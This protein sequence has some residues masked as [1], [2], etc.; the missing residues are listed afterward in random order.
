M[1]KKL[2]KSNRKAAYLFAVN[3]FLLLPMFVYGGQN[4]S[5]DSYG[6][7][8]DQNI[9]IEAFI[10]SYRWFGALIYKIYFCLTG[11][12]PISNSTVDIIVFIGMVSSMITVLSFCIVKNIKRDD[13]LTYFTVNLGVL[14]SVTNVWFCDILSFPECIFITTVGVCLCFGAII[15]Y[16]EAEGI[17]GYVVSGLMLI[18]ATGVYQQFISV[19]AIY[20]IAIY[21]IRIISQNKITFKQIFL[22]YLKPAC[23]IVFSGIVYLGVGKLVQNICN[24][25]PNSRVALSVL[26]IKENI[27]YFAR[28][29]HSYLK[30]RGYFS[31]EILTFCFL[32]IGVIWLVFL[33]KEWLKNKETFK[34]VFVVISYVAAYAAAFLPGILSTSHAARA[35]FALFAVFSLFLVGILFL[36]ESRYIK[37]F[38]C[39][40][41]VVVFVM[42]TVVN[43]RCEL[44]LKEQNEVDR[45]WCQ[46]VLSEI[47]KYEKEKDKDVKKIYYCYDEETDLDLDKSESAVSHKYSLKALIGYYSGRYFEVAELS[48]EL[49]ENLFK[50]K[51][52]DEFIKEEQM[53]F[54]DDVLYLCCY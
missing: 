31:S 18:C 32:L 27:I 16:S 14:I 35:M 26:S 45:G 6:V 11:H 1:I 5:I 24:I 51:E 29:Q 10:G 39:I 41:L 40:I 43:V 21:G 3:I 42:N 48:D 49:N 37:L 22:R 47:D 12:N 33:I 46:Q 54:D 38:I 17:A 7:A 53:V 52:W 13:N 19:F 28:N 15:V 9:H 25:K 23:H 44:V 30:G 4:F 36:A 2:I 8:L 20:I 50:D 34:S